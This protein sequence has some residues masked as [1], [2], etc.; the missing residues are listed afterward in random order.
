MSSMAQ[1][2]PPTSMPP[3]SGAM[4]AWLCIAIIAGIILIE[5]LPTIGFA[6]LNVDESAYLAIGEAMLRGAVPYIDI[7][8]RKPVG[9]YVIYALATSIF[10]DPIIGARI[11]GLIC[12]GI[13]A[14]FIFAIARR[15]LHESRVSA[16]LAASLFS[17]FAIL[18]GGD[19]AQYNVFV[20]PFTA[21]AAWIVFEN[22]ARL[23]RGEPPQALRIGLSGLLLGLAMQIKYTPAFEGMGFGLLLMAAGWQFRTSLGAVGLRKL[24]VGLVLMLVGG[25][26]PTLAVAAI[27]WRMDQFDAFMFYNFTVNVVRP[28]TDYAP[29]LLTFRMAEVLA[30]A[31]PLLGF[32]FRFAN[33]VRAGAVTFPVDARWAQLGLAVWFGAALFGALVQRQPYLHYFYAV[34]PPLA[35]WSASAMIGRAGLLRPI[36]WIAFLIPLAFAGYAGGWTVE[37]YT[38]GSAYLPREIAQT[39]RA[40]RVR[41][42]YVFNW[43]GILYH[44]SELPSPTRFTLPTHLLRDLE[45]ASFEFDAKPEVERILAAKPEVIVVARPFAGN[46]APDRIV[47]LDAALNRGYCTWRTYQAGRDTVYL[48]QYRGIV[49]D[50]ARA[51]R[52]IRDQGDEAHPSDKGAP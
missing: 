33:R 15:H 7:I 13:S 3:R 38:H 4:P 8:D 17:C 24:T 31:A 20:M 51:C 19:A 49:G 27:Y 46:I 5:R 52:E 29:G 22:L 48:Y 44:L 23:S 1:G 9:L 32:S 28:V 42:L 45:A 43:F 11:L 21:V 36:R 37:T 34:V 14:G 47:L 50:A 2:M 12:T 35:L 25:L 16:T 26:A 41:S 6:S 10:S 39:L 40:E 30:I 18:Y